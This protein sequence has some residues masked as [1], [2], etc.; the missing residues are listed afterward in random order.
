MD[1]EGARVEPIGWEDAEH[2]RD[3]IR[4]AV[5]NYWDMRAGRLAR[6]S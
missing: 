1:L 4:F 6:R 5:D 2:A 3:R